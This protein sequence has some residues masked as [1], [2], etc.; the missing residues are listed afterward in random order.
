MI[1][2][3]QL[4]VAGLLLAWA[5]HAQ[6]GAGSSAPYDRSMRNVMPNARVREIPPQNY[7]IAPSR[8]PLSESVAWRKDGLFDPQRFQQ[9]LQQRQQRTRAPRWDRDITNAEPDELHPVYNPGA[10]KMYF[11]SNA[12][13]VGR[14][15]RG[16]ERLINPTPRYR[17]W[18]G[19]LDAG[20]QLFLG[21][22]TNLTP[23][24]G[25]TPDEQFGSQIQPALNEP[26]NILAYA[27]RSAAGSYNIVVRSL[28]DPRQR[29]VLT[30][31]NDGVTHNLHPTLSPGGN[32]VVF[33]SNRLLPG[34]TPATRRYRLFVARADGRPF[35]NRE[36]YRP[37]TNPDPGFHD[38]EPAW[39]PD[40]DQ[41]AFVRIAPDGSS[42][43][44]VLDFNTLSAVQWTS[45]VDQNGNRPRD[46]QPE[47][48][49]IGEVPFLIFASTRKSGANHDRGAPADRV[50]V[51]DRIYNIFY[52]PALLP[53]EQSGASAIALTDDPSS[54]AEA[55][56]DVPGV[57]FF[58]PAAGAKYP[59][60]AIATRNRV[61]YHSTRTQG[62]ERPGPGLHDLWE[63]QFADTTPP[64]LEV[65][66][67]VSPKEMF[68]GDT[69][70]IKVRVADFQSGVNFVRVQFKDPDSAEQDAAGV[71][72]RI[73]QLFQFDPLFPNRILVDTTSQAYVPLFV[74]VGQQ[75]INPRTY[76]Y[77]EP[78]SLARLGYAG[79]LDD[80]LL[81]Q[82]ETDQNGNP[83]GWYVATWR[84]PD[85]P[86]D[87]YLD[88]IVRDNA[89]N[90]FIY[91][92]VS[93]F[94]TQQF[95]GVHNILLVSDYMGGQIFVQNRVDA[96]GNRPV[97][98]PTWQPVESYWT[99]N[100][101]GKPPFDVAQPPTGA[102]A[103]IHGDG[104]IPHPT[105]G[106]PFRVRADTLGENTP[107]RNLYNIWRVQC[108]N[109]ITPAVLAGYLP[110][111]E[112][113]PIDLA[114]G[115]RDKLHATR[116]VI[117]ASPY[118]GNVWAGPGHILD[119]EIQTL[120]R[121]FLQGSG[122]IVFSGQD[123]AW[124]LSLRGTFT[125]Q[126]L[127]DI[128]R[129]SFDS[130][131][132]DDVFL[133]PYEGLRR[134]ITRVPPRERED[135]NPLADNPGGI[136]IWIRRVGANQIEVDSPAEFRLSHPSIYVVQP[137]PLLEF[138]DVLP[139]RG[140]TA[141]TP[142]FT[143][144]AW[145]QVWPD[146][147][148]VAQNARSP[149]RYVRPRVNT[150]TLLGDSADAGSYY[151]N[152]ANRSKVVFLSF[153]LEGVN[154]FYNDVTIG[155]LQTLWC[156]A[157][158]NKILHNAFGWM[159]HSVLEGVVRQYDPDT[160]TF[161]PLPRA[162]VRVVGIF[163][164]SIADVEAGYAITDSNGFYRIVGLE[165]GF[166]VVDAQ[167]PGFRTQ[168]PETIALVAETATINLIM[169]ATPPGQ[170]GGRVIDINN[171]PVRGAEVTATSVE[172]PGLVVKVLSDPDGTFL[173]PRV[174]AGRW[175]VTVERLAFGGY[176][177]PPVEPP[178]GV[179]RDVV[180]RS[181]ETVS[182]GNFVLAPLPGTVKGTVT[183]ANT[184]RPLANARITAV[185]AGGTAAR[186]GAT[187]NANGT[188][189]FQVPAGEYVLTAVAPGYASESRTV[190][191][192]AEREVTVN[193]DLAP[194][195]PGSVTGKVVR[196]FGGAPEP[197]VTVR[198]LLPPNDADSGIPPVTTDANGNYQIP[199]VPPGEYIVVP[200]KSG[201]TF[202]PSRRTITVEPN[203]TTVVGE[204]R[205]EPLR[206]FFKGR[207]LVST[208][209][210][211]TQEVRDLL[212]VP[213]NATFRFFTW[214]PAQSRYVFYPN[215][216]ANR[217][218][219]G[220]G[221]FI[222]TSEDLALT[223]FGVAAPN[224]PFQIPLRSGW[225][226]IGNPFTFD[227]DW[228]QVQVVD[229]DTNTAISLPTAAGK[230]IV[231]NALWGYSFGSYLATTR[232]KV[233]EGYWVYAYR[234]TRLVI[235]PSAQATSSESRSV[236][237]SPTGW[238]LTLE[239]QS[240]ELRDRAYVGV[241]RAATA[242]YDSE[243]DLLKPPPLGSEYVYIS[244]PRLNWGEQ[245]GLYGVDIQPAT[246]STS[247][248]F[249]VETSQPNRE[250]T[251]RWPDMQQLPRS[252]NL[253]LVNLDTGERRY[254]R[255]TGAYT[256]RTG[257]SG[258]SRFRLEMASSSRLLRIQQVQISAGRGNQHTIAFQL[259]GDATVQV[260]IL[261]G[262]KVVRQL[263]HQATRSGGLQQAIWDGR[264]QNG[265]A[266]PPGAYTVEIQAVS[267]DG[268][269]AR[270]T[271][272]LMLTR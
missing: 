219:L 140:A 67:E 93:G 13:A 204:F 60:P 194:L 98:R 186:G 54:P 50:D 135:P 205:A 10:T 207:F 164:P 88:V 23:I 220:R 175:N 46:R 69:V 147:V 156:R 127:N 112:R 242:G 120:I 17:I 110:R 234:D 267:E 111:I 65:L 180:V 182:V 133:I 189:E 128:M 29:V 48:T 240:G 134:E 25:D 151:I 35:E 37:I 179:Y 251:L 171:Q 106:L 218:Q 196:R 86:S 237:A 255:T 96:I 248:E 191:V 107:Y 19:D 168:H 162:L 131:A 76:E 41:I 160:R 56:P 231:A 74:E 201:F 138:F 45:F 11:A 22:L 125:N 53:E 270:A 269:V 208:P 97:L 63:T 235:P 132:A 174:P 170:I 225:N 155:T 42:Y 91:D 271:A 241:S 87:F 260:N 40:R 78:Y 142:L 212:S 51:T 199:N 62:A 159:T 202:I 68:P 217:F 176:S 195:P 18:R 90:E 206:T 232:L 233:W 2:R 209:Y 249:A 177:L 158:R 80:T 173:I 185:P 36:Y 253:V 34:D 239:V 161:S 100:P 116:I 122:R 59:T 188:Y 245:S 43:I 31:D 167:R 72:H 229:P 8:A 166:Y 105:L 124:A 157:Y 92:N 77:K 81:L 230:R 264:D 165:A 109:P 266:L 123:I 183:D 153:G 178:G 101:T 246:R 141:T 15:A 32:L 265:I 222:E 6:D 146:T 236:S 115:F 14:D 118:T 79:S 203:R 108:R 3:W 152:E 119:P 126:F 213:A 137:P 49:T 5:G 16:N 192:P 184:G 58:A 210:D 190:T 33:S 102:G 154:S 150:G 27:N 187:T 117:W 99:D 61:A 114:G 216:P 149:Y 66:P 224:Q 244:L 211:Y 70:T 163:P 258:V 221:Y 228:S 75:A 52:I 30:T 227:I 252:A 104:A 261:S 215:A 55:K 85:V 130:D 247:W 145:N 136:P 39:A 148:D 20:N 254:L 89:D 47:W 193:F 223:T 44:Y 238:R 129:V 197:G 198:L 181:G 256:F 57:A 12:G 272:P 24:T 259:T 7:R 82:P 263:L 103:I 169:V 143:D 71:E 250:V 64:V 262:G 226:L 1:R 144:A 94:T 121:T 214:D 73:Y 21:T 38:V 4:F 84:T 26:A 9:Q 28:L 83:T 200:S 172:D 139:P 243:H 257:A 95:T 268:Q 113:E